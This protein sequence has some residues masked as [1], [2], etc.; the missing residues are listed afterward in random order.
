MIAVNEGVP[1][2]MLPIYLTDRRS[3]IKLDLASQGDS[4][5]LR[6]TPLLLL[7]L[8]QS[9]HRQGKAI[10]LIVKICQQLFRYMMIEN[11]EVIANIGILASEK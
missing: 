9:S 7:L 10:E 1:L 5:A 4:W 2:Q 11:F 3:R 6:P 8:M